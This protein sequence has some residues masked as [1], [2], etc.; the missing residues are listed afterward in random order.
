M[1]YSTIKHIH[2]HFQKATRDEFYIAA[3]C[4]VIM[5]LYVTYTFLKKRHKLSVDFRVLEQSDNKTILLQTVLL[6]CFFMT[7]VDEKTKIKV[8]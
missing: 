7:E 5:I 4:L 3:K 1:A 2:V 8:H 6:N